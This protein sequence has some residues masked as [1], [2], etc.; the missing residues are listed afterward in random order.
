MLMLFLPNR[1]NTIKVGFCVSKKVGKAV[2]RNLVKRRLKDS[3]RQEIPKLKSGVRI[4]FVAREA[5]VKSS[6][7]EIQSTVRYL[8]RKSNLYLEEES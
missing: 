5:I 3:F 7:K 6:Y 2:V 1:S 4:V 8:L